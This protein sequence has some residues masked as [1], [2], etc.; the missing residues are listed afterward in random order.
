MIVRFIIIHKFDFTKCKE[1]EEIR[2]NW[3][4]EGRSI[5]TCHSKIRSLAPR[6]SI[7]SLSKTWR[8]LAIWTLALMKMIAIGANITKGAWP[9]WTTPHPT[10]SSSSSK[11]STKWS[12]NYLRRKSRQRSWDKKR[13]DPKQLYND[14]SPSRRQRSQSICEIPWALLSWDQVCQIMAC[15]Y[16]R[17]Y[18]IMQGSRS[19]QPGGSQ[20]AKIFKGIKLPDLSLETW[21]PWLIKRGMQTTKK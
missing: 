3:P 17:T 8:I 9:S 5:G 2:E 21:V 16:R 7:S 15:G 18:W 10:T 13:S 20:C 6:S 12:T 1:K 19:R 11:I 4:R 14:F